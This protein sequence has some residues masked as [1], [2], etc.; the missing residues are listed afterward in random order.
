MDWA[1]QTEPERSPIPM[2]AKDAEAS[3]AIPRRSATSCGA[4]L[5]LPSRGIQRRLPP[6][7][8]GTPLE[9][10]PGTPVDE[11][12]LSANAVASPTRASRT[13]WG[14]PGGLPSEYPTLLSSGGTCFGAT[15]GF[16]FDPASNSVAGGAQNTLP[17]QRTSPQQY[18][19]AAQ[20]WQQQHQSV[21][22]TP[23]LPA[24]APAAHAAEKWPVAWAGAVLAYSPNGSPRRF[25]RAASDDALTAPVRAFQGVT[26]PRLP[27]PPPL[28]APTLPGGV[29]AGRASTPR[30]PPP[31]RRN[32]SA[33]PAQDDAILAYGPHGSPKSRHLLVD[34]RAVGFAGA[35]ARPL[36]DPKEVARAAVLEKARRRLVPVKVGGVQDSAVRLDPFFP[37]KKRPAFAEDFAAD[38]AGAALRLDPAL[39]WK[40]QV[41]D[42][43]L[44]EPPCFDDEFSMPY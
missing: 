28:D 15:Y 32:A 31:P 39:P 38:V 16:N 13:F 5:S 9:T 17:T 23:N 43:L 42:F 10:I 27:P 35:G 40:K 36:W 19:E 33:P 1:S 30:S 7:F 2:H 41:P 12:D 20:L 3:A 37:V 44:E 6:R 11:A 8:G 34:A 29:L 14:M 21:I 4:R 22:R 18:G 25:L 26:R 24:M